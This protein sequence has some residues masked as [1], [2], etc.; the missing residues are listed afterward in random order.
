MTTTDA[1]AIAA[2]RVAAADGLTREFGEGHWSAHTNEAAVLR[3]IRASRVLAVR[4]G[5]D[6]VGTLTLQKK[7]PWS[8]DVSYF[9][10]CAKPLYLINMAVAPEQQGRGFGRALLAEALDVA[11]SLS[12]DALRLDAYDSV[13][14]AGDF[15]R[16][17]GYTHVGGRSYR[18][19]PLLYFELMTGAQR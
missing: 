2:V 6:I 12:A 7:K 15:Y 1:A 4:A 17:C 11:R 13:A 10:P 18:G 16:K 14:G 5:A 3:D 9:T 19:V 8:I